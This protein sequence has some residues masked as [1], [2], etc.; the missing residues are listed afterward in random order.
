MKTLPISGSA[1]LQSVNKREER[2]Q[3]QEREKQKPATTRTNRSA[4][5]TDAGGGLDICSADCSSTRQGNSDG[6][7]RKTFL[8]TTR[9]PNSSIRSPASLIPTQVEKLSKKQVNTDCDQWPVY[10]VRRSYQIQFKEQTEISQARRRSI[11]YLYRRFAL[12]MFHSADSQANS[13]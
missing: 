9:S 6:V 7:C 2:R 5:G 1:P 3:E 12:V 4:A 13:A 11:Q 8:E 10:Q